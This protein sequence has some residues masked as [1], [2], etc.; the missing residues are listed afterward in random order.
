MSSCFQGDCVA[1][2]PELAGAVDHQICPSS[3]ELLA[4]VYEGDVWLLDAKRGKI[5]SL[6]HTAGIFYSTL[7]CYCL[8]LLVK[9]GSYDGLF[10]R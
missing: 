8:V 3:A 10:C 9:Y 1:E 6:T 7:L 5:H 2:F 4:C